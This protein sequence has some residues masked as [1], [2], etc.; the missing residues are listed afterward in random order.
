MNPKGMLLCESVFLPPKAKTSECD[1][2]VCL[3]NLMLDSAA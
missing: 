3:T 1:Q 2:S